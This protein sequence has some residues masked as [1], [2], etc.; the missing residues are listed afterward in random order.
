MIGDLAIR[1]DSPRGMLM[2]VVLMPPDL[3]VL[4]AVVGT[5]PP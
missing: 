5:S 3:V 2:V 1:C 4:A